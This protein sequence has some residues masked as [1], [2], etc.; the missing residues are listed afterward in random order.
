MSRKCYVDGLFAKW[1]AP[2]SWLIDKLLPLVSQQCLQRMVEGR[3]L[4]RVTVRVDG[5]Q[6]A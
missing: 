5:E 2:W 6:F 4:G 1:N 3:T